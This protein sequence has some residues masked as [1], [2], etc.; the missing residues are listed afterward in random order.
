MTLLEQLRKDLASALKADEKVRVSTLRLLLSA[1]HNEEIA[2]RRELLAEDVARVVNREIRQRQESAQEYHRA[3]R[4]DLSA[5]EN[6]EL[7]ILREYQPKQ[8]EE[9]EIEKL[10]DEV[11]TEVG[12][13]R[14]KDL[15]RVMSVLMPRLAGKAE[16][17]VVNRIVREKLSS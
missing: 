7:E 8:M 17:A 14:P 3:G 12:A 9:E 1:L 13:S 5:K 10:A 6:Q 2:L 15:G 11:I 16:G 4:D